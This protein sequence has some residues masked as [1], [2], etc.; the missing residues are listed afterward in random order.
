MNITFLGYLGFVINIAETRAITQVILSYLYRSIKLTEEGETKQNQDSFLLN[1]FNNM[2]P[3]FSY[4]PMGEKIVGPVCEVT[5]VD[6]LG[7][8]CQMVIDTEPNSYTTGMLV[9]YMTSFPEG[10]DPDKSLEI[11]NSRFTCPICLKTNVLLRFF[12]LENCNH[13]VCAKCLRTWATI[14]PTCPLC[15]ED[16]RKHR[17]GLKRTHR[18]KQGQIYTD[19]DDDDEEEGSEFTVSSSQDE[20]RTPSTSG[21]IIRAEKL[22]TELPPPP[23]TD[24]FFLVWQ[25]MTQRI[26]DGVEFQ[27]LMKLYNVKT[28]HQ[29]KIVIFGTG[30]FTAVDFVT[31]IQKPIESRDFFIASWWISVNTILQSEKGRKELIGWVKKMPLFPLFLSNMHVSRSTIGSTITW[32]GVRCMS[33]KREACE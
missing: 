25:E 4:I 27:A 29:T 24:T 6:I 28:E 21:G 18:H 14:N 16:I 32:D 19:M 17:D 5:L 13:L 1:Y 2:V 10:L 11:L 15:R 30:V 9:N 22:M 12:K 8:P 31:F 33:K 26:L 23:P 20:E 3:K 7:S